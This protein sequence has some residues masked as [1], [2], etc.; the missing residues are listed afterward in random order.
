MFRRVEDT[1]LLLLIDHEFWRA[2]WKGFRR[3]GGVGDEVRIWMTE[4]YGMSLENEG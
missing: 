2:K 4:P 3:W 1:K